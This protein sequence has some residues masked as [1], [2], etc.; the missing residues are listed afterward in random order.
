VIEITDRTESLADGGAMQPEVDMDYCEV[1]SVLRTVHAVPYLLSV[2]SSLVQL[3][4]AL[5]K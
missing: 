5:Y 4:A 1:Q 3:V 2:P